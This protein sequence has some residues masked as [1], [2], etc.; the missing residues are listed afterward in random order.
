[1]QYSLKNFF[2]VITFEGRIS[3]QHD[4]EDYTE[5][6]GITGIIIIT[7]QNFRSYIVGG[8]Y[9][10]VHLLNSLV[11]LRTKAFRQSKVYQFY[12]GVIGVVA[13]QEVLWLEVTVADVMFVDMFYC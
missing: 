3:T 8:S 4:I 7:F 10:G 12:L 5:T 1:L 2:I 9:N 11:R 6:P 13:E